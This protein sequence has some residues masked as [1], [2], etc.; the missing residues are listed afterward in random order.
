MAHATVTLGRKSKPAT[1]GERR[2]RVLASLTASAPA[3]LPTYDMTRGTPAGRFFHEH[4]MEAGFREWAGDNW[5]YEGTCAAI[6]ADRI[7][8][9]EGHE[10]VLQSPDGTLTYVDISYGWFHVRVASAS[11][12]TATQTA[13][14]FRELFPASYLIDDNR[15]PVTFWA[16][17]KNGPIPR[18]RKIDAAHWEDI[19]G[20][21]TAEVRD[22]LSALMAWDNPPSVDGQLLLWQGAPGT[23][24]SWSLRALAS[25]W[26]SWAEF[27]YITDPDAFFVDNPSYMISVLLSDSY[28]TV[29][30]STGDV[31]AEADPLGKWR[32]LILEDT[33]EL[34]SAGAKEK[35]GQGL[36]RL[37]N[38][39]DGMIGQGL[40]VLAL[41]TTNDELGTLHPAVTRPGR[42]ASQIEFKPMTADEVAAWTGENDAAEG[43]TLAELYAR[44]HEGEVALPEEDLTA[45]ANPRLEVEGHHAGVTDTPAPDADDM[46][47]PNPVVVNTIEADAEQQL[48][49]YWASHPD[50]RQ[51][52]LEDSGFDPVDDAMDYWPVELAEPIHADVAATVGA[53][54]V[55]DSDSV[56]QW[57]DEEAQENDADEAA[58][59][60]ETLTLAS[61][62]L[63][64]ETPA[65]LIT[66][67]EEST[68]V[69]T[70]LASSPLTQLLVSHRET[71]QAAE[72]IAARRV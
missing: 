5:P 40:R 71:L 34:L 20:N 43:A 11:N 64:I 58:L 39:V 65:T 22:E 9:S 36:S 66:S 13:M 45:D 62:S 38:V 35:Y 70:L 19:E 14:A 30:R 12:A 52:E 24:K 33:G 26:S 32:I 50:Q 10:Y 7:V 27:H 69:D 4:A 63:E 49:D 41:V 28:D 2:R 18:L 8:F 53:S 46:E 37:L 47:A 67:V 68:P 1:L 23:G 15:V 16:D 6:P 42:C 3:M 48:A 54:G 72:R 61:S 59:F 51:D 57:M 56:S 44:K 55:L 25:E 29:E 60:A 31:Y 21:Y 17:S